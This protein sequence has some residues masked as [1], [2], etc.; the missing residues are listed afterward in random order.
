MVSW[1][2]A[3]QALDACNE[4]R[5]SLSPFAPRTDVRRLKP[6]PRAVRFEPGIQMK[7][8]VDGSTARETLSEYREVAH[9]VERSVCTSG[10]ETVPTAHVRG[11]D[12]FWR[13]LQSCAVGSEDKS[14]S[15]EFRRFLG[16]VRDDP[17]YWRKKLCR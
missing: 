3:C 6:A 9:A 13:P 8:G 2:T 14:F 17:R 7:V 1:Q 12:P 10:N 5:A 4:P 11:P 15:R 16:D